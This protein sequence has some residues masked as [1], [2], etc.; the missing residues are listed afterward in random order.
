ML[1]L[2]DMSTAAEVLETLLSTI[3]GSN[4]TSFKA[5]HVKQNNT[6]FGKG[7]AGRHRLNANGLSG[8]MPLD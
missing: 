4:D 1:N 8:W 3:Q 5:E 7:D 6:K 2:D